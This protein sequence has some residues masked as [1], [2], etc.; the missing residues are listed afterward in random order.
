M[1][2]SK[3]YKVLGKIEIQMEIPIEA[4]K[5]RNPIPHILLIIMRDIIILMITEIR[6]RCRR[7]I[8]EPLTRKKLLS[9]IF[10][11]VKFTGPF[12]KIASSSN[13]L[14]RKFVIKEIRINRYKV[15]LPLFV[16][17]NNL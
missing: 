3:L 4:I 8:W 13:N 10:I 7:F 15:K 14:S 1:S 5:G 16:V 9:A 6:L 17:D 2:I 12:P 11:L